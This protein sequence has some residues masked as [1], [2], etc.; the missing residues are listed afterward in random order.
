M[1]NK[2]TVASL[3]H[4]NQL[5]CK[6][7]DQVLLLNG[8]IQSLEN[9]YNRAAQ[10]LRKS[11]KYT[12]RLRLA[13]LE[14]LRSMYLEFAKLKAEEMDQVEH[15]MHH[16]QPMELWC[17]PPITS[18]QLS[19]KLSKALFRANTSSQKSVISCYPCPT[20]N[21]TILA[22]ISFHHN[23]VHNYKILAK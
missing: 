6:A 5:I 17:L 11:F 23:K 14:G 16:H 22:L 19:L 1:E 12:L 2:S 21:M 15:S 18:I 7:C 9:R 8:E 4:L 10:A 13:T 20:K 3:M